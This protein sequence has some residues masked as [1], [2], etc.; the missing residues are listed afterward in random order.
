MKECF[1][2]LLYIKKN[3]QSN[4]NLQI[5]SYSHT[6][7]IPRL[8]AVERQGNNEKPLSSQTSLI[9]PDQ[10]DLVKLIVIPASNISTTD[11][12]KLV[13][14]TGRSKISLNH[15]HFSVIFIKLISMKYN[16]QT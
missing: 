9:I 13:E 2:S 12:W 3:L 1:T 7:H 4:S 14:T 11:H 8:A 6:D 15:I 16:E 10:H 5:F